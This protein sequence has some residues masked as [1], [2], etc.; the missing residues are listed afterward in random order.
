MS[1]NTNLSVDLHALQF[2]SVLAPVSKC[3]G[4]STVSPA[5]SMCCLFL[6]PIFNHE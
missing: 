5:F 6:L 1:E 2:G 3:H 4:L